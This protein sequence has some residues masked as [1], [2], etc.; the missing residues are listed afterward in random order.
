LNDVERPSGVRN[1]AIL[2][3]LGGLLLIYTGYMVYYYS[4]VTPYAFSPIFGI[5]IFV[6][7]IVSLCSSVPVWLQKSWVVSIV[8]GIGVIVCA[9]HIIFGYYLV[10]VVFAPWYW[11]AYDYI[12]QSPEAKLPD[13]NEN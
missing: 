9:A 8:A 11:A 3:V 4:I 6:L 2:M 13:L 1:A 12:R 5:F 7:G 10:V